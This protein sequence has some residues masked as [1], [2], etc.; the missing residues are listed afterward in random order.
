MEQLG[1]TNEKLI[2]DNTAPRTRESG[3]TVPAG[4]TKTDS[5]PRD[6]IFPAMVLMDVW[7]LWEGRG[8]FMRKYLVIRT[9]ITNVDSA[10]HPMVK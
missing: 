1:R 2:S 7:R 4:S 3:S 6:L 10:S 5:V 8:I 9:I